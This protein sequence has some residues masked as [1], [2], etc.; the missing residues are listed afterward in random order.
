M[1]P[2]LE[3]FFGRDNENFLNACNLVGLD[4]NKNEFQ[5]FLCSNMVQNMMT[6][7]SW[8]IHIESGNISYGNFNA[9]KNF[10]NFLLM[11][12]GKT[13]QFIPKRSLYHHSFERYMKQFLPAFLW[14][15]LKN[16]ICWQ[17]KTQNIC[18]I[19]STIGLNL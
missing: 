13:K 15:K 8:S 16:R 7:N 3:C 12:Q 11:Q 5:S 2:Q 17:I 10:Y 18:S 9:N 1:L 14:K 6:N 4:E 19:N